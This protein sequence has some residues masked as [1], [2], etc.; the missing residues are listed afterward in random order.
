MFAAPFISLTSR[1]T[2]RAHFAECLQRLLCSGEEQ[3]SSIIELAVSLPVLLLVVT[4]ILSFGLAINNY[5]TLTDATNVAARQ[6][7]INRGQTT[8]PCSLVANA[9]YGAAPILNR[10]SFTFSY[11]LNG[12]P[13]TG[14]SCSSLSTTTGAAGNLVQG[15]TAVVTV[16][17]PCTL[18]AYGANFSP[19]CNLTAQTAELVQ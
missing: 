17:Y 4:G 13:Y 16:T 3:G 11:V 9:V 2:A 6:L 1:S 10:S 12:T 18:K 8:D 15:G 19:S 14:T 5:I 7:A